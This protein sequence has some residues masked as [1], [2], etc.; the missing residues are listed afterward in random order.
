VAYVPLALL[1]SI[2][3][4]VMDVVGDS[5]SA[6]RGL[7]QGPVAMQ[8]AVRGGVQPELHCHRRSLRGVAIGSTCII[9]T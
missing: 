9:A 7:A 8:T 5:C 2:L 6:L 4:E 3:Y 1:F